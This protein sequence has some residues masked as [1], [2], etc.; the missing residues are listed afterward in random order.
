VEGAALLIQLPLWYFFSDAQ[1]MPV[2]P[3]AAGPIRRTLTS[4]PRSEEEPVMRKILSVALV[5][6]LSL[7]LAAPVSAW[8]GGGG[9]GHG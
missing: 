3:L 2:P 6:I 9:G 8:R 7:A 5:A 1:G 4:G